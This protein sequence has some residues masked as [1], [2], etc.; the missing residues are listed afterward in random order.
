MIA[1]W[2]AALTA[3]SIAAAAA[4]QTPTAD[5]PPPE[6][7]PARMSTLIV[8]GNDPCPRSSADEI[9]VCAREPESERY[10]LPRRFREQ[11]PDDAAAQ[12]WSSRVTTLETVS[13]V[14]LPNSC[15][16]VGSGGATGCYQM[17]MRMAREE[18]E[19]ARREAAGVP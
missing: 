7:P 16:V 12:A 8:Y 4:A 1:R 10:R 9:V 6:T 11:R 5:D 18:R 13:R 19:Q 3:L 14:G 2:F 15:S 17:F